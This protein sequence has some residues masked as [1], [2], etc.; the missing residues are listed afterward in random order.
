NYVDFARLWLGLFP[1]TQFLILGTDLIAAKANFFKTAL[2]NKLV[3]L[4]NQT[5]PVQAFALLQKVK[6]VLS[7]DSG[8]MHMAWVSGIPTLAIFGSTH[9]RSRPLGKHTLLLDSSD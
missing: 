8:L 1:A 4:V 2:A 7:E 6:F 3:N 5:T 9:N